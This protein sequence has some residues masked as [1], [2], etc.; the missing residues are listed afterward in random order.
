MPAIV[1]T[2]IVIAGTALFIMMDTVSSREDGQHAR[3]CRYVLGAATS[4]R[5]SIDMAFKTGCVSRLGTTERE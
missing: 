1:I 4:R 3:F 2:S 5:D